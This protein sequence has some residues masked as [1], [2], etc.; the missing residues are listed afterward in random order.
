MN[1]IPSLT[2]GAGGAAGPAS[3]TANNG[4]SL[5]WNTP[6]NFDDSGWVVNLHSNGASTTAGGNTGANQNSQTSVPTA[7]SS[8]SGGSMATGA[9]G[10]AAALLGG[11]SLPLILGAVGVFLL[12]S[13][14]M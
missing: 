3:G 14:K 7:S 12:L 1:M 10:Q 8:G 13:H 9:A 11:N 5:P 2:G 4:L 6:F